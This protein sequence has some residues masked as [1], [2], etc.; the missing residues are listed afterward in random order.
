M[1]G[2]PAE[3]PAIREIDELHDD[4]V[5]VGRRLDRLGLAAL[6]P[7]VRVWLF[8]ASLAAIAILLDLGVLEGHPVAS[9]PPIVFPWPLVAAGF[10]SPA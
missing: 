6:P 5:T 10:C 3:G 7:A 2:R 1:G 9:V 8:S 4:P